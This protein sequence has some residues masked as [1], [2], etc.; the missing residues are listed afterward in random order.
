MIN[1]IGYADA[2]IAR[3]TPE[4]IRLI[5]GHL[6]A[7]LDANAEVPVLI[8]DLDE[9]EAGQLLATL[10][11][12]SAMAEANAAALTDLMATIPDLPSIDFGELYALEPDVPDFEPVP[13]GEQPRLD[14]TAP[15]ICPNCG[16]EFHKT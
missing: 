13:N 3:E 8:V 4:G 15:I 10:D 14:Q 1:R 11:P 5:D 7:D 16:H 12:L 6:R 9:D 2:L